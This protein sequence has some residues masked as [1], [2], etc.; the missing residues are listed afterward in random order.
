MVRAAA[1]ASAIV[2]IEVA[3]L[4]LDPG[5]QLAAL[6]SVVAS[7]VTIL[8]ARAAR[9]AE[10]AADAET[11]A[12]DLVKEQLRSVRRE[13]LREIR[14]WDARLQW[15]QRKREKTGVPVPRK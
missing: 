7:T 10:P 2:A 5:S 11:S 1:A 3:L 15:T 14:S 12:D 13:N 8:A 9:P 4:Q 6:V